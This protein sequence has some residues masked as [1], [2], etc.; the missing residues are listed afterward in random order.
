LRKGMSIA[1]QDKTLGEFE[2]TK[3]EADTLL[4]SL[5]GEIY[6]FKELP[7]ERQS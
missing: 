4:I 6:L 5:N 2:C 3:L 1:N 7:D